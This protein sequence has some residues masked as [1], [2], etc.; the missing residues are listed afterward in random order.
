ME[1]LIKQQWKP[2]DR[3]FFVEYISKFA[4]G[5]ESAIF[6]QKILNT[7]YK[8]I[9]LQAKETDL[10]VKNIYKGNYMSFIDLWIDDNYSCLAITGKLIAKIK[11]YDLF[12][13]YILKYI[14]KV[15]CWAGCDCLKLNIKE[16]DRDKYYNL[17]CKLIKSDLPF[18]RRLGL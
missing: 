12:E 3:K 11:D 10:I 7:N 8:C 16:Q 15:D 18:E 9:A 4:K 13:K 2:S 5:G 1:E 6:E 17:S 14:K